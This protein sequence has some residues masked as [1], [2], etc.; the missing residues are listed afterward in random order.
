MLEVVNT[1][2]SSDQENVYIDAQITVEFNKEVSDSSLTNLI[3]SLYQQIA[4]SDGSGY[5][6]TGVGINIA[7]S[8]ADPKKVYI[9]PIANLKK[10]QLH[11]L[12]IMGDR[13]VA[14]GTKQGILATDNDVMD[15]N[16]QLNYTTGTDT[17]P[18]TPTEID[19][20]P[21]T[22]PIDTE[23]AETTNVDNEGNITVPSD[24]QVIGVV[25][26]DTFN[27]VT[28]EELI[29][30]F[31]EHI[32]ASD[33]NPFYIEGFCI[34]PEGQ[35]IA[36]KPES[37]WIETNK[38]HVRF[39]GVAP[40]SGEYQYNE[41]PGSLGTVS[42]MLPL[43]HKYRFVVPKTKVRG[44]DSN[45]HRMANDYQVEIDTFLFPKLSNAYETRTASHGLLGDNVSDNL[46][47]ISLRHNTKWILDRVGWPYDAVAGTLS[48]PKELHTYMKQW[49]ICKTIYDITKTYHNVTGA[50]QIASKSLGDFS[51][52]YN[53]PTKDNGSDPLSEFED[54]I[55]KTF[56]FILAYMG[57]GA[58]SGVKSVNTSHYPGRR[59]VSQID[60]AI[61]LRAIPVSNVV[62]NPV[63][64]EDT[65][66]SFSYLKTWG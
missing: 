57:K 41:P 34:D 22:T 12:S 19:I 32:T 21:D 2:P 26:V 49:V 43:N 47:E 3:F 6:Y 1:I 24:L 16:Y 61:R 30:E 53:R 10:S 37:S 56:A 18:S 59:R 39:T 31:N 44:I 5:T 66:S 48:L 11:L 27:L 17:A 35:Y 42:G 52:S 64:E 36:L 13:N 62:Q 60:N 15:G 33:V 55:D 50:G 4:K 9:I 20:E 54:C 58:K 65:G 63:L 23:D 25:P 46:I 38:L 8:D 45:Q 40:V 29:I 7:K 28:L 51:I 14:D